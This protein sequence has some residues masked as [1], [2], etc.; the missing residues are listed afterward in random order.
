LAQQAAR[1][2]FQGVFHWLREG[3]N[4][5]HL[6]DSA[7]KWPDLPEAWLQRNFNRERLDQVIQAL[8]DWRDQIDQAADE[9]QAA[10]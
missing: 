4:E 3:L 8:L 7:A 5:R 6:A 1:Q 9:G 10:E 2:H